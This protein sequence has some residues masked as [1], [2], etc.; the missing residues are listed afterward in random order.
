MTIAKLIERNQFLTRSANQFASC[1]ENCNHQRVRLLKTVHGLVH[2][3]R[4][5][6]HHV[7]TDLRNIGSEEYLM[8]CVLT[9]RYENGV[10]PALCVV[11]VD[12]VMLACSDSTF[13]K[14]FF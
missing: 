7:A 3:P 5:W 4:R 1:L 2:D 9:L 12:S 14:H 6:Y 8:D 13:G 11:H 10:I